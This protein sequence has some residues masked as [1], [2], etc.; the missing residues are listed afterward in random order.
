[1]ARISPPGTLLIDP[2]KKEHPMEELVARPLTV[3]DPEPSVRLLVADDDPLARS[4]LATR[5]R[6]AVGEIVVLEAE[7]GAEAIQLGLQ[8]TPEIAL[9]DVNMPRL[10]GIEAAMTL[11]E[12]Q[13]E[14]RL[15]LQ[16]GDPL[17]HRARADAERLPLF[18]KQ[19][20]DRTLAWL[21]AQTAW[22]P[23]RQTF[24]CGACGYGIVRATPPGR[25]P[26]CRAE[27]AWVEGRSAR[28]GEPESQRDGLVE[29]ERPASVALLRR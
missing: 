12:L 26:M 18:G 10:G 1:L 7:D 16:T 25:C 13:P 2:R 27:H 20:L 11:R 29:R 21:R 3:G 9:L 28:G 23:Q 15:A 22:F 8:E 19:E 24:V 17:T 14:M 4:L 6:E 5:A